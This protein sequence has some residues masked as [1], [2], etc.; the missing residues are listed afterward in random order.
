MA[1]GAHLNEWLAFQPGLAIRRRAAMRFAHTNEPKGPLYTAH[2]SLLLR[3]DGFNT[4]DKTLMCALS[5]VVWLD[6]PERKEILRKI[7]ADLSP[8]QRARFNS[9]ITAR[10]RVRAKELEKPAPADGP[11]PPPPKPKKP[12]QKEQLAD[13][14]REIEELKRKQGDGGSLCDFK[15]SN[16]AEIGK[17]IAQNVSESK[18]HE[19]HKAALAWYAER[20]KKNRAPAG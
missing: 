9:P 11:P 1:S 8:G 3:E 4:E 14:R 18:E 13:A 15:T 10:Q 5:A 7:L 19:I 2:Y 17:T 12:T 16:A 20:K 6:T